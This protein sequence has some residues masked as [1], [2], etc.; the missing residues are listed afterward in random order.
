[1]EGLKRKPKPP[2]ATWHHP[3][4]AA[5]ADL[6]ALREL[7]PASVRALGVRHYTPAQMESAIR[8]V[9]GPDTQLIDDGT[10]FVAEAEGRGIVG[11]GGWSRRRKLYGGDQVE[12]ASQNDGSEEFLDPAADP[13]RI[14]AFF[15]VPGWERRGVA[16]HLMAKCMDAIRDAGFTHVELAATLPGEAFYRWWG[17]SSDRRVETTLPDGTEIAFIKMSYKL[18]AQPAA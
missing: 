14:R 18:D 17:F 15:V 13:A 8:Y 5:A 3:R 10:Y 6:P 1:M 9:F 4:L 7:I 11:C 16:T 12:G 2:L